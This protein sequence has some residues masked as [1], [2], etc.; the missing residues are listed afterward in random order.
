MPKTTKQGKP[1]K[2]EL[3][4]TLQKS[5]AKAQRTFAK[6]HDSAVKEYGEGQR[7]H[8]VAYSALK[9]SFEKVGDH[10]EPKSHRG[11]S[12]QRARSGGPNAKGKSAGGVD[13][14]STKKH[15]MEVARRL[16]VHGRSTMSK[17]ELVDAIGRANRRE[18]RSSR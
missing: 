17:D 4:S 6:A 18:T 14:N 9:H 8:R 10:W 15:L 11:P 13:A 3:P 2:D 5:S 1:K 16:D 7:A 12:D